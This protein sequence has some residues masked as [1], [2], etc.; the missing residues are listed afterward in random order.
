MT[1]DDKITV[2]TDALL[3]RVNR[4]LVA[5]G[6]KLRGHRRLPAGHY[7][8]LDVGRGV[9]LGVVSLVDV[10]HEIGVLATWETSEVAS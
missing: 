5:R 4:T 7:H 6:Q 9:L 3:R 8:R 1:H 10:A 2:K